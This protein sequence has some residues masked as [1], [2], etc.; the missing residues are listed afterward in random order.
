MTYYMSMPTY[1]QL[2]EEDFR[3]ANRV[4][5]LSYNYRLEKN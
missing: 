2:V 3:F 1:I 4:S 5:S